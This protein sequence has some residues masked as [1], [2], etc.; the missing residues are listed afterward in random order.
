[1]AVKAADRRKKL[2]PAVRPAR[3]RRTP[4]KSSRP[5]RRA[6]ASYLALARA[7]PIRPIRSDADLD[8]AIA[9]V[10]GLL[11]RR[12]PLDDQEQGYLESLSHEIERYEA[13]A[14]PMPAVSGPAM[15]RHLID[16]RGETLSAVAKATGIAVSTLSE[17]LRGKRELNLG[18]IAALAP[19]F[20]VD[21]AVFIK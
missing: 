18:H 6:S 11:C 7:Y 13:E 20:G 9:V 3:R 16:A 1:M 12:A 15:L 19:H 14:H 8:E 10:D 17:I 4:A 2:T 5:A 21:P